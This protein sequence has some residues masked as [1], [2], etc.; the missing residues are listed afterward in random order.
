[1]WKPEPTAESAHD[2]DIPGAAVDDLGKRDLRGVALRSPYGLP[3]RN[4][5]ARLIHHVPGRAPGALAG[6]MEGFQRVEVIA[7]APPM[8]EADAPA[9]SALLPQTR[10]S[11]VQS[12]RDI[13]DAHVPTVPA[14]AAQA[15]RPTIE[16]TLPC[17]AVVRVDGAVDAKALRTVLGVL[18][19]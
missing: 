1:M 11:K 5:A 18:A 16:V 8:I 13:P 4:A 14:E 17:G 6:L 2:L 3:P 19:R 7:D 15:P 9:A 10:D 12:A